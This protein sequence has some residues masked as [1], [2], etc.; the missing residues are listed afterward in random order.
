MM[1]N[2]ND[3]WE[4]TTLLARHLRTYSMLKIDLLDGPDGLPVIE[5]RE[6]GKAGLRNEGHP[7]VTVKATEYKWEYKTHMGIRFVGYYNQNPRV[8]A[9]MVA[10]LASGASPQE[11][12]DLAGE[13]A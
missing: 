11:M 8:V 1:I 3:I 5:L 12:M 7:A 4:D 2:V 10:R 6:T 9:R 13:I